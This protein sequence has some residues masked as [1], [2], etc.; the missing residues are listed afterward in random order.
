[1][2]FQTI[3]AAEASE[4]LKQNLAAVVDIRD[5][6][7]YQ[8]G[9]IKGAVHLDNDNVRAFIDQQDKQKPL[10]V[11]CYHGNSSKSAAQFLVEQGFSEVYSLDGGY[12]LWKAVE[13]DWCE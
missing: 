11:C 3:Q 1:M 9:H 4:L 6:Q 8:Q 10:I 13:P 2:N 7:S 12:E 5:P